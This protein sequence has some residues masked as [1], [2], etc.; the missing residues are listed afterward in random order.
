VNAPRILWVLNGCGLQGTG[1]SGGVLRFH[2]IARR[3]WRDGWRDQA[4]LA[5][6]GGIG[7]LRPMLNPLPVARVP[8]GIVA[9]REFTR[10][11]RPWSY[12][13]SSVCAPRILRRQP[14]PDAVITTSD[15]F[16]DVVPA[17]EAQRQWPGVRW[18]AWIHH[19]ELP[20][21]ERP[22]SRLVNTLTWHMQQGSF[23]R[24]AR[25]AD[26]AWVL[27][28]DAGDRVAARLSALGM[29]AARIRRM[30]NGIDLDA[31]RAAPEP[32]AKAVDAV[33]IG[34]RPNKGLHDIL[35]VWEEV[36][37][38]RPGTTLRLMGGLSAAGPVLEEIRRRGLDRAIEVF[39][40]SGGYLAP[41]D[42]YAK[43]K[44]ARLLFAP[45]HEEGWG[46]ALA[47]A[48]ACGLPVVAYD[49]PVYRRVLADTFCAVPRF[50]TAA[51]AAGL[52]RLLDDA[53]RMEALARA[54][55]ER[56]GA[57]DWNRMAADDREATAALLAL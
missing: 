21:A 5:T 14:R 1:L 23:R 2:E 9:R 15:Y 55:R 36:Q 27:D 47:E 52:A 31:V 6:E 51:F 24:I 32:A 4:L 40:P 13:V 57:Y 42:Y 46:I 30:R 48:Q 54:G 12:L 29:A 3:W 10:L 45:S 18:I 7:V 17:R 11:Q 53:A 19:Q 56:A 50:E 28:T 35:P 26:Q 37:R 44:E 20:P 16:C 41:A 34:V 22:G 25:H 39:R 8:A 43:V 38:L 49:L 33:M